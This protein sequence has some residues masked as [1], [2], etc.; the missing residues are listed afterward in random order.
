M[1]TECN[2]TIEE[3]VRIVVKAENLREREEAQRFLLSI[4]GQC[5]DRDVKLNPMH[6]RGL[7][8]LAKQY[9]NSTE[10][11]SIIDNYLARSYSH[12]GEL[13]KLIEEGRTSPSRP[14]KKKPVSSL[15]VKVEDYL[16]GK[17]TSRGVSAAPC[18]GYYRPDADYHGNHLRD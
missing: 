6:L 3:V 7:A 1:N 2:P 11:L 18:S 5:Q 12:I 14:E 13:S 4:Y 16:F 8:R 17:T 15:K 10:A 9:K